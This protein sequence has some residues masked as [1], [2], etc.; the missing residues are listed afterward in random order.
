MQRTRLY[1]LLIALSCIAATA[2][3][4]QSAPPI[5]PGLWQIKSEREVDGQKAP[6]PGDRLKNLPPE[7]RAKIEAAMKGKGVDIGSGGVT[8]LCHSSE[9]LKENFVSDNSTRCKTEIT[10]RSAGAWKWHASCTQPEYEADGEAVFSGPENY[11]VKTSMTTKQQG[12]RHTTRTSLAA[13]WLSADCADLKP[14]QRP[15]PS[16]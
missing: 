2:A 5:K 13:T 15:G 8:R 11:T 14:I 3:N 7:V 12:I 1:P 9:S 6:D 10:S 16:R 4:A